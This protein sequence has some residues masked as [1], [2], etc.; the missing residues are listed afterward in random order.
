MVIPIVEELHRRLPPANIFRQAQGDGKEQSSGQNDVELGEEDESPFEFRALE[1]A[2]EAICSFLDARTTELETA[3]YPALDELT[4]KVRDELEQLLDDDDDMADLYL[5]RKWAW[6]SSTVSGSGVPNWLPA[7]PTIGSKISKASK[8]SAATVHGN[9]NDVE[10]L[11]M[12]LEVF[13]LIFL[14]NCI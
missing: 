1:V 4:S 10:E 7:S 11:E 13:V 6:A 2:L 12:L 9:E 5:S 3:A 8:A 14:A